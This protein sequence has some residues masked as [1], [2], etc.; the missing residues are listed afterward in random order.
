MHVTSSL[1]SFHCR[2]A[3]ST[4][5]KYPCLLYSRCCLSAARALA[6]RPRGVG[7]TACSPRTPEKRRACSQANDIRIPR[8]KCSIRALPNTGFSMRQSFSIFPNEWP[9]LVLNH[10]FERNPNEEGKEFAKFVDG[11]KCCREARRHAH[12]TMAATG[13]CPHDFNSG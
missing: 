1:Q 13:A 3:A 4:A 2:N 6:S 8:S 5:G 10:S 11:S 12:S 7:P 9:A